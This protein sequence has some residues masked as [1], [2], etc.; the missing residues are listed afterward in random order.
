MPGQ[1]G[2]VNVYFVYVHFSGCILVDGRIRKPRN[3]NFWRNQVGEHVC[4][5]QGA[6]WCLSGKLLQVGNDEKSCTSQKA[7]RKLTKK[8]FKC[9]QRQKGY[10]N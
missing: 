1:A 9:L 4:C 2:Q 10:K 6:S 5:W 7:D 8:K 3:K